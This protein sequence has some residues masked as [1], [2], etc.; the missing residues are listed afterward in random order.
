MAVFECGTRTRRCYEE[1]LEFAVISA[2]YYVVLA[3]AGLKDVDKTRELVKLLGFISFDLQL[4]CFAGAIRLH[5]IDLITM[6]ESLCALDLPRWKL[7]VV[8]HSI[9]MM[10]LEILDRIGALE[11]VV[12]C[13]TAGMR[14]HCSNYCPF[15]I[16]VD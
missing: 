2:N 13:R 16:L 1:T 15:H 14:L 9:K 3:I 8:G 7:A 11:I 6:A 10:R 5:V 4:R 12:R